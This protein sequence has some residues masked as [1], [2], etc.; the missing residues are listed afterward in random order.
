MFVNQIFLLYII[1]IFL[2]SNFFFGLIF[3]S[4]FFILFYIY[5]LLFGPSSLCLLFASSVT[6]VWLVV[7]DPGQLALMRP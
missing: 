6:I 5:F 4:S 7:C 3:L 2:L 1:F